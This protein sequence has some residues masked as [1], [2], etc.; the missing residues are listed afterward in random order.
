MVTSF[1]QFTPIKV[2][3]ISASIP[4]KVKKI[5]AQTKKLLSYKKKFVAKY[6]YPE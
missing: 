2:N 3:K 5:E 1:S 4:G 6:A